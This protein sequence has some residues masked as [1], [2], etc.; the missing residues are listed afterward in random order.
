MK[1]K[2]IYRI[3]TAFIL[4]VSSLFAADV[5]TLQYTS[6]KTTS[7]N[8][9]TI[10]TESKV[11]LAGHNV[12]IQFLAPEKRILMLVSDNVYVVEQKETKKD[13]QKYSLK[14]VPA[15]VNQMLIPSI[16]G[17]ANFM[18]NLEKG[19]NI[20]ANG[21]MYVA[22][23]KNQK[24]ISKIEYSYDKKSG[25]LHFYKMY[26]KDGGLLAETKFSDYK[27]FAGQFILPTKIQTIINGQD[28]VIDDI[29]VFSRIKVD[30]PINKTEFEL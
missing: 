21:T 6:K 4:L 27:T 19:F 5:K 1:N 12:K 11:F 9:Q 28:G 26:G 22:T 14:E 30:Q 15:V 13:I 7:F 3:I 23:P 25:H 20:K 16:F 29:E 18:Q 8:G 17:A 10:Q 2:N 24:N